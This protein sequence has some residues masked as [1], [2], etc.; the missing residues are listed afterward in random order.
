MSWAK[1]EYRKRGLARY[2]P[3]EG[4]RKWNNKERWR[5]ARL[6][7]R[8]VLAYSPRSIG[9]ALVVAGYLIQAIDKTWEKP[10]ERTDH[11]T[12]K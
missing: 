4:P 3:K 6:V 10:S 7:I 2:A 8:L 5:T 9:T 11:P 12:G 1:D